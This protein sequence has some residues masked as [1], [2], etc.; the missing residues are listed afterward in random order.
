MKRRV[1]VDF[2]KEK[3]KKREVD[4]EIKHLL[5][6]TSQQHKMKKT[7]LLS[8]IILLFLFSSLTVVAE[9]DDSKK[10]GIP[11]HIKAEK[12]EINADLRLKDKFDYSTYCGVVHSQIELNRLWSQL[13]NIQRKFY[14]LNARVPKPPQVDFSKHMVLW[15]AERG[16]HASF[17][18][19]LEITEN[20][21]KNSLNVI[22]YVFH[23]DFGSS[24]LNLWKIPKTDK[25]IIFKVEHKY[26]RGP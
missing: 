8:S 2:E 9:I 24:N 7:K 10:I 22:V 16:V 25:E 20:E 14:Q 6:K 4:K 1:K 26:D 5:G 21:E 17:V 12:V 13:I 15:F 3:L 18:Q 11:R 23:S 19:S